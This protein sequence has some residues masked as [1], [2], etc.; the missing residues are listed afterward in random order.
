MQRP[1]VA[2]II[3][4]HN[5][6]TT[7][8]SVVKVVKA[9]SNVDEV[10]VISD[11]STDD[12]V[13]EAEGEEAIIHETPE[14]LGKGGAMLFGLTKTDA[15]VILFCDADLVGFKTDHVDRLVL[16]VV[17]G[18][19]AMN[20]GL[21]DRGSLAMAIGSKLP[22]ISGERAMRRS[23]IENIDPKF[24]KGFMIE[25]AFNYFCRSRKLKYGS[26]KLPGLTIVRKYEKVGWQQ[27]IVDYIKMFYQ[28]GKAMAWV[29][30]MYRLGR[31]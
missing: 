8:A 10:L 9:S 21:R 28:V 20:V 23:V 31:F 30:L 26:V 3:P 7:V 17:N 18:A 29:R 14:Q 15:D 25:S 13:R 11:G 16:P 5:E 12:T 6:E 19:R 24:M 4:A 1:S 22:L 27:G 2:A